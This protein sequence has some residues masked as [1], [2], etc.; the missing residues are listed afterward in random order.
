MAKQTTFQSNYNRAKFPV[1][2]EI[3]TKPSLTIPDQSFTIEEIYRRFAQGRPMNIER[4]PIYDGDVMLPQWQKLD[5]AE[6][7]TLL[8]DINSRVKFLQ[9]DYT[10]LKAQSDAKKAQQLKQQQA[11]PPKN[12]DDTVSTPL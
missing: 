11:Q 10:T 12:G 4:E 7:E 2:G 3:N 9:N 8:Q 6:R 1:Q 5:L